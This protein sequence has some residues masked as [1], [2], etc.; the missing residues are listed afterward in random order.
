MQTV[1]LRIS[2]ALT[3]AKKAQNPENP[4]SFRL[5]ISLYTLK[6][7][8]WK[9]QVAVSEDKNFFLYLIEY[10]EM[11]MAKKGWFRYALS[12]K[13]SKW[14]GERGNGEKMKKTKK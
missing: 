12:T 11:S 7:R 3:S 9:A 8:N 2:K 10:V 13:S 4:E 14:K 6:V 5:L 1:L